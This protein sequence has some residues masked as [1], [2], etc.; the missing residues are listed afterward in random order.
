MWFRLRPTIKIKNYIFTV[1]PNNVSV[2][3]DSFVKWFVICTVIKKCTDHQNSQSTLFLKQY[4]S[5]YP[6]G[7]KNNLEKVV[8]TLLFSIDLRR[9]IMC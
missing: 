8:I 5:F 3:N 6:S 2:K 9:I 7:S 4:H 1:V